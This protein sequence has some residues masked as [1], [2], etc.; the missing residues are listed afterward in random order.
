MCS[1]CWLLAAAALVILWVSIRYLLVRSSALD[2]IATIGG[3]LILNFAFA[4]PYTSWYAASYNSVRLWD[5]GQD[6]D[7]G[8]TS[9]F[10]AC[11]CF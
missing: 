1:D 8:H 6:A 3:F 2:L 7:L 4:L 10:T 5:G 9:I 11:S